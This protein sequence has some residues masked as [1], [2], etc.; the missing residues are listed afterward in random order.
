MISDELKL[1]ADELFWAFEENLF[2][3]KGDYPRKTNLVLEFSDFIEHATKED[4][5]QY[6][7]FQS[8]EE[9]DTLKQII[10]EGIA[11]WLSDG[12]IKTLLI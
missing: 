5:E 9:V 4:L 8:D 7:T 3:N 12:D 10:R 6:V 1:K 11:F 2:E